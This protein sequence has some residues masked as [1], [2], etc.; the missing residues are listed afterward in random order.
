M[1]T[2]I[3]EHIGTITGQDGVTYAIRAP[4]GIIAKLQKGTSIA[5]NGIC[6]TVVYK[7]GNDF[8]I[9][10]MPETQKKTAISHLRRGS[11]VNLELPAT[12]STFLSGHIVQGHIDGVGRIKKIVSE[13][14]GR[15]FTISIPKILSP[16][17]VSKGSIALNGVSLT[18]IAAPRDEFTV[19]IIPFTRTHT[20]LG[21][22]KKG[23]PVNIE[24]DILAKYI[25]SLMKI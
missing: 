7:K 8:A 3:I 15:L 9:E 6:C 25:R 13:G 2:G 10:V 19:G 4:K 21:R 22:L 11:N 20:T 1:F 24:V 14:N 12:P 18:I 23:D 17:V 5:I 16:Y